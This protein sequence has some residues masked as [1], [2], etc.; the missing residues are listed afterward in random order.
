MKEIKVPLRDRMT[1]AE[2]VSAL[3]SGQPIDRVPF[4]H[5]N[6]GFCARNVGYPLATMY[7]D[8]EKSF[9]AQLWTIKQYGYDN[10]PFYGYASYGGWEFGG[11]IKMPKTEWESAPVVTRFPVQKLEDV[12][13][14]EIP[15]VETAGIMP[16][17]IEY[18][19]IAQK[20]GVPIQLIGG[21]PF[22]IAGN[23]CDVDLLCRWLLKKPDTAHLLLKKATSLQKM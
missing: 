8:P 17:S 15:D 7:S 5:F 9:Q 19:K 6:I 10:G 21:G 14:L 23:I 18:A 13:A 22:T 4:F 16:L 3:L 2:R 11:D 12:E 20:V 1:S